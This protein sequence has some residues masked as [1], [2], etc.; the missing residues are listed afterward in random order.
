MGGLVGG[1]DF[2][3]KLFLYY[4]HERVWANIEWGRSF[5]HPEREK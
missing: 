2:F 5:T 1:A 4:V 3:I